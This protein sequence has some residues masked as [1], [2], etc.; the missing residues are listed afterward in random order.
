MHLLQPSRYDEAC[1]AYLKVILA[2][3]CKLA[4]KLYQEHLPG[5]KLTTNIEEDKVKGVP[6]TSCF[7]ESVFGQMD[8]LMRT[9]PQLKTLAAESCIM[10]I[11]TRT[12]E[13]LKSK[14]EADAN[15]IINKA[16]RQVNS[17][18]NR[19]KDRINEI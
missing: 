15:L 18:R 19:F 13:W 10:F 11:N 6:K 7:A 16:S 1:Q 17:V 12:L 5:G 9:K 4:K 2:A 14:H 8:Q 3:L